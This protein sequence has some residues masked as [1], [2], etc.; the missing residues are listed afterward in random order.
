M[1]EAHLQPHGAALVPGVQATQ[2]SDRVQTNPAGHLQMRGLRESKTMTLIRRH[3]IWQDDHDSGMEGWSPMF[4]PKAAEFIPNTGRGLVHDGLEHGLGEDG[5][6][7]FEVMAFGRILA[8]RYL[9]GAA[10]NYRGAGALG[11]ELYDL[12]V[13]D[14]DMQDFSAPRVGPCRDC[15]DE[16]S[17]IVAA[18]AHAERHDRYNE[19]RL[20]GSTHHIALANLLQIGYRDA[21]RRYGGSS[22]VCRAGSAGERFGQTFKATGEPDDILV[23]DYDTKEGAFKY[24]VVDRRDNNGNHT[25]D[26]ARHRVRRWRRGY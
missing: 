6:F 20:S 21:H 12:W 13:H 25:A 10:S 23:L 4:I 7:R 1:S 9:S 19:Y 18:F 24:R 8:L 16:I 15:A 17:E 11:A 14:T 5:S 26:W 3:F 22:G 2:V